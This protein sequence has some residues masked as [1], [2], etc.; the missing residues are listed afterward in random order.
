MLD[1][2]SIVLTAL[3]IIT[4]VLQSILIVLVLDLKKRRKSEIQE[5]KTAI[6]EQ[7]DF[8]KQRDTDNR[9]ARKYPSEQKAKSTPQQSQNIDQVERSLRDINLRLKNAERD[10]E[11]ERKRI[12]DAMTTSSQRR[13]DHQKQRERGDHFRRNERPRHEFQ[14]NRPADSPRNQREDNYPSKNYF[15]AREKKA[16]PN[17]PNK[18]PDAPAPGAPVTPPPE[19]AAPAATKIPEPVFETSMPIPETK[20]NLQHGRKFSVK[21]R[22]LNLEENQPVQQAESASENGDVQESSISPEKQSPKRVHEPNFEVRDTNVAEPPDEGK[23]SFVSGPISFG[24]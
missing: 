2:A 11:K 20:E 19:V 10:Q 5:E 16:N 23:E 21:R 15:E 7:R 12:K 24:R 17:V 8:R 6:Y 4:I 14:H 22:M 13:F 9:F 1:S 3:V 18:M